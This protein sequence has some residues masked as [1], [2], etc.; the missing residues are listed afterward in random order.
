MTIFIGGGNAVENWLNFVNAYRPLLDFASLAVFTISA[1]I[2]SVSAIIAVSQLRA[3]RNIHNFQYELATRLNT[4]SYSISRNQ[5]YRE[6]R[7]EVEQAFGVMADR[8]DPVTIEE[9][10]RAT[11]KYPQIDNHVRTLLSNYENMAL[12]IH[13]KIA[14]EDVAFELLGAPF[15]KTT[16]IFMP[17]IEHRRRD[18]PSRYLNLLRLK[19]DWAKRDARSIEFY[20]IY[21]GKGLKSKNRRMTEWRQPAE[22]RQARRA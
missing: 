11:E 7:L 12:A 15:L 18:R 21:F 9:V 22:T 20:P 17:Y 8:Q 10:A 5:A 13:A 1:V 4:L 14:D 19:Q 3:M 2:A 6:A 16:D